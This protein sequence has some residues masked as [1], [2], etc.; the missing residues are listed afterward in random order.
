MGLREILLACFLVAFFGYGVF[1]IHRSIVY[2]D[3]KRKWLLILYIVIGILIVLYMIGF[4]IV[5]I[6]RGR[7]LQMFNE[8]EK[9]F[10]Q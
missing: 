9:H 6:R 10:R 8:V 3:V 7:I 1:V 4:V 2:H 5:L